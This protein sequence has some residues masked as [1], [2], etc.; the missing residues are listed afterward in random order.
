MNEIDKQRV[1]EQ[2]IKHKEQL[3]YH[4]DKVKE[5]YQKL[6]DLQ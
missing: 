3:K 6:W 5:L 1:K 4:Q 2:I